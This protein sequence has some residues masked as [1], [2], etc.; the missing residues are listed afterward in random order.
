MPEP[1][2]VVNRPRIPVPVLL[3][4]S[5]H[6][7]PLPAPVVAPIVNRLVKLPIESARLPVGFVSAE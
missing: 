7:N 4:V 5:V 2:A 6:F 3:V 1:L